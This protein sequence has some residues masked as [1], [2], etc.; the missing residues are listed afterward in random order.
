MSHTIILNST[1]ALLQYF[2]E[3]Q[4]PM[5]PVETTAATYLDLRIQAGELDRIASVEN[6]A[7][8]MA[9]EPISTIIR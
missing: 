6:Q 7:S 1:A 8:I 5:L 3:E 4:I 2:D 9:V